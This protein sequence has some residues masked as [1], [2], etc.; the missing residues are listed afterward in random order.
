MTKVDWKCDFAAVSL[1]DKCVAK[2]IFEHFDEISGR[3]LNT[4]K[5]YLRNIFQNSIP[6]NHLQKFDNTVVN[7]LYGKKKYEEP[8]FFNSKI[9]SHWGKL[10]VVLKKKIVLL[11]YR[12]S[13]KNLRY[14]FLTLRNDL[15]YSK[16]KNWNVPAEY[17][18][19]EPLEI[20]KCKVYQIL[21]QKVGLVLK[22]AA[23]AEEKL[24]H[25]PI[26]PFRGKLCNFDY[27]VKV[28]KLDHK[29]FG[30]HSKHYDCC[31]DWKN[32]LIYLSKILQSSNLVVEM[33]IYIGQLFSFST[34]YPLIQSKAQFKLLSSNKQYSRQKVDF[35]LV[36][37]QDGS[38]RYLK[39]KMIKIVKNASDFPKYAKDKLDE[40]LK[41]LGRTHNR[42]SAPLFHDNLDCPC[43]ACFSSKEYQENMSQKIEG[44]RGYYRKFN[45]FNWFKFFFSNTDEKFLNIIK[46]ISRLSISCFDIESLTQNNDSF[47]YKDSILNAQPFDESTGNFPGNPFE[48]LDENHNIIAHQTPIWI[49]F[50]DY[51]DSCLGLDPV[52]IKTKSLKLEDLENM[53]VDFVQRLV[54]SQS[55]SREIKLYL[56]KDLIHV[57]LKLRYKFFEFFYKQKKVEG[58][59]VQKPLDTVKYQDLLLEIETFLPVSSDCSS[60]KGTIYFYCTFL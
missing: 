50:T 29:D 46:T 9:S 42:Q 37:A 10:E 11:Y 30:D 51:I 26:I 35:L 21:P 1:G 28:V 44:Q 13:D 17:F 45:M 40:K 2:A 47:L 56:L 43:Y 20:G 33:Y 41:I 7:Y 59:Y 8:S 19:I 6:I 18:V 16:L 5:L 23:S 25:F 12:E 57:L 27:F 15:L 22:K 32:V 60:K 49:G 4:Y 58:I 31:N 48:V 3:E 52:V 53:Y 55:K 34:K 14:P 36:L 24:W 39:E 54:K 38:L